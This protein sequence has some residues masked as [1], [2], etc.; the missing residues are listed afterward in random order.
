MKIVEKST[1]IF[2]AY[3]TRSLT[4]LSVKYI[5]SNV[6]CLRPGATRG[7]GLLSMRF[8]KK[9]LSY[10]QLHPLSLYFPAECF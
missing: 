10:N 5:L 9:K 1:N 3:K 8:S 2:N 4:S 6:L 7:E